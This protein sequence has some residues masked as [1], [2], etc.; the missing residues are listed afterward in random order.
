M[1]PIELV[2]K[3][4][5]S[6]SHHRLG[7][8]GSTNTNRVC[9]CLSVYV[10]N[11]ISIPVSI[12]KPNHSHH[13]LSLP[14]RWSVNIKALTAAHISKNEHPEAMSQHLVGIQ[15]AKSIKRMRNQRNIVTCWTS[16]ST[17]HQS[18]PTVNSQL[19]STRPFIHLLL[20]IHCIILCFI[21]N[22]STLVYDGKC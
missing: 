10:S 4:I 3:T 21:C 22:A 19:I 1:R 13:H 7:L 18:P 5:P 14:Y 17:C 16:T 20:V 2:T 12:M 8:A 11:L 9:V 15:S 6:H